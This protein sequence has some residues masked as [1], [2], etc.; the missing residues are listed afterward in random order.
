M[1][2]SIAIS[3]VFTILLA[4][5]LVFPDKWNSMVDKETR[6]GLIKVGYQNPQQINLHGLKKVL[7]LKFFLFL[8]S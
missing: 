6:F 3:S 5:L 1:F 4:L 8:Q 2:I 7:Y